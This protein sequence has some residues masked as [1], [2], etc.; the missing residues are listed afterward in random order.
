MESIALVGNVCIAHK[1]LEQSAAI[2]ETV[3]F[4]R[5]N[6][7]QISMASQRSIEDSGGV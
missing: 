2:E 4:A 5:P 7:H 3:E 1:V 6:L